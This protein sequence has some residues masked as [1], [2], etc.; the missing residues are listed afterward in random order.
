[1]LVALLLATV[2]LVSGPTTEQSPAEVFAAYERGDDGAVRRWVSSLGERG[3]PLDE[4]AELRAPYA[5]SRTAAAFLLEVAVARPSGALARSALNRGRTLVM[6]R[7]ALGTSPEDDQFEVLWHHAALAVAQEHFSIPFQTSYLTEVLPRF[8]STSLRTRLPLAYAIALAEG[9]CPAGVV[10]DSIRWSARV[11]EQPP[12]LA[13]ALAAFDAAAGDT[14]LRSEALL[15]SAI[16]LTRAGRHMD[17]VSRLERARDGLEP[18]LA[19][20][21]RLSLGRALLEVNRPDEAALALE[22]AQAIEG[23]GQLAAIGLA[24]AY[25]QV[26]RIDDA[27]AVAARARRMPQQVGRGL[28]VLDRA[29]GRFVR[30]WLAEIRRLRR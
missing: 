18:A 22:E 17:A 25:L 23:D 29:D 14:T 21:H 6:N 20:V 12:T 10:P 19:Y 1:M 26:G 2:A 16:I 27:A 4:I 28:E 24:A 30:V 5:Y 7:G 11:F 8:K 9:C 13:L 15:R 3:T